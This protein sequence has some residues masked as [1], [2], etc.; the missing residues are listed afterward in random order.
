LV[1][2]YFCLCVLAIGTLVVLH[3]HFKSLDK[4][5]ST[6]I[7]GT[8][9]EIFNYV[10]NAAQYGEHRIMSKNKVDQMILMQDLNIRPKDLKEHLSYLKK[11][12]LVTDTRNDIFITNF[13]IEY[14]RSFSDDI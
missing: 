11:K 6:Q 4:L 3:L 1:I 14:Y 12:N 9:K 8:P 2:I 13:G 7:E 5:S 10:Y